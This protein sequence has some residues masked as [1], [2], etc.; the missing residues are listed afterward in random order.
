MERSLTLQLGL[1]RALQPRGA[2]LFGQGW[3]GGLALQRG[4][5][6]LC[7][8][9]ENGKGLGS[10]TRTGEGSLQSEGLALQPGLFSRGFGSSAGNGGGGLFNCKGLGLQARTGGGSSAKGALQLRL[11]MA[12]LFSCEGLLSSARQGGSAEGLQQGLPSSGRGPQVGGLTPQLWWRGSSAV[13]G[14]SSQD[15]G[16][17]SAKVAWLFSLD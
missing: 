10:S 7:L 8:G 11:E 5:W 12:W 16:K 6:A 9:L 17:P 13:R 3:S 1:E 2:W 15:R 4:C 14:F